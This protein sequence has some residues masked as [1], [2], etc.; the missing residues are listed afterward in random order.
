MRSKKRKSELRVRQVK[1]RLTPTEHFETETMALEEGFE[2]ISHFV[3]H[4]IFRKRL[5]K[6][7]VI[8]LEFQKVFNQLA[9]ELNRLGNNVNQIAKRLNANNNYML[10]QHDTVVLNQVQEE[11]NKCY[12]LLEKH[13]TKI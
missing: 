9:R 11:L 2:T 7:I 10:E 13:L 3:R 4:R 1:V 5:T 12:L 8:E 6:R